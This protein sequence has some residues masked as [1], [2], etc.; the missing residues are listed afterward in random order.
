MSGFMDDDP[1]YK[2]PWF[3]IAGWLLIL[4]LVYG[5]QIVR[6]GGFRANFDE[7]FY[8]VVIAFPLL[9]VFWIAFFAQFVLPVRTFRDRQK[10]FDRLITYITR[11]HGPALFI[12]NGEIQEHVG[13]RLK[14]GPGVVWLD[15]ASAA[16]TRSPVAIKQTIGPGVYFLNRGES[17]AGIVDLHIQSQTLGPKEGEKPLEERL[18]NQSPEEWEQI[19]RRRKEVSALTR[20]GIEVVPNVSISF[21]VNT[22]FPKEGEPGSR[23]GYRTGNRK[24][25]KKNQVQ[26]QEAIYHAVLSEGINPNA[27]PERRRVAWNELPAALAVDIWREYV[28]KFTLDELFTPNQ[29]FLTPSSPPIL[30]TD[31]ETD[32]LSQPIQV[33]GN[34][35][36]FLDGLA[37]MLRQ[38]NLLMDRM[39]NWL[40]E[41]KGDQIRK[42]TMP[43][44][45]IQSSVEVVKP[46]VKT[47]LQIINEMVK[48]RLTQLEVNRLNDNGEP[49]TGTLES[50]EY[51]LLQERGLKVLSVNISNLRFNSVI[52]EQLIRQWVATWYLNASAESERINRERDVIEIASK[53]EAF[54]EY[55]LMMSREVND[56]AERG[57][58]EVSDTLKALLLRSRALIRSG[59]YG[60]QLRRRMR[61]ELQSIEDAIKWVEGNDL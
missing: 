31:E 41:K 32:P 40:E 2:R 43:V 17:V 47:G 46:Q 26:D 57:K 52:D 37:R 39:I 14:K 58:P 29:F 38:V 23:F 11:R 6:M 42:P 19:Q 60:E 24:K 53:D 12:K 28:A 54:I 36:T 18:D 10:I 21:R 61:V 22:G 7:I 30:P 44:D 13:E 3:Y 55:A 49:E 9:L 35:E 33:S 1:I 27:L 8:D 20:D 56:H 34:R 45:P 59:K 50:K 25:D 5:W 4:V 51:K 48:A 15:S 16:V